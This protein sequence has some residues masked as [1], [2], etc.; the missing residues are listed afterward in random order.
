MRTR[1]AGGED[2]AGIWP[3]WH[4][5]VSAGETHPWDPETDEATARALWMLPP[6]AEVWVVEDDGSQ[7]PTIVA[8]AL[9]TANQPGLGNHVAHASFMV[10]P[11]LVGTDIGRELVY[12]VMDRAVDLG[13]RAMQFN[14]VVAAHPRMVAFWRS[15]A[16]RVIGTIPAGFRH[17]WL[18]DVDLYIMHRFLPTPEAGPRRPR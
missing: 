1:L 10:D 13:Y 17:P 14:A 12:D 6:P 11:T 15:L 3:I 18:G 8:T 5:V 2:W 16:F 9:L 4:A 7:P